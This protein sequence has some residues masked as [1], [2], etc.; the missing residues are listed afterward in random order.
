M[1]QWSL[2]DETTTTNPATMQTNL[3]TFSLF[4]I[5]DV[6][7][8]QELLYFATIESVTVCLFHISGDFVMSWSPNPRRESHGVPIKFNVSE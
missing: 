5:S 8:K 6:I 4:A 7:H 3:K 1:E 2:A